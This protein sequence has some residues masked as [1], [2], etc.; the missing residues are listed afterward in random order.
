MPEPSATPDERRFLFRMRLKGKPPEGVS[1]VAP[2]GDPYKI[3]VRILH[4][5]GLHQIETGELCDDSGTV[6]MFYQPD[7]GWFFGDERDKAL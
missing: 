4:E 6:L 5:A 1:F 3:A 7:R 2:R